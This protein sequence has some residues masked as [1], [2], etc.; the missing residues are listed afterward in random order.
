[1]TADEIR[2]NI[3]TIDEQITARANQ[4]M[5]AD[6]AARELMGLK[7]GLEFGLNGSVSEPGGANKNEANTEK[8]GKG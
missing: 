7:R 8:T 4:L 3:A 1:M 6:P 2:E 5:A